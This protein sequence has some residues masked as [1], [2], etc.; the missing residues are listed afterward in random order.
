MSLV[1]G[2]VRKGSERSEL[3]CELWEEGHRSTWNVG[4]CR[5]EKVSEIQE[6]VR[7]R[8]KKNS[9]ISGVSA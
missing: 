3:E 5:S 1:S 9:A 6:L 8:V 2:K 4:E 7:E